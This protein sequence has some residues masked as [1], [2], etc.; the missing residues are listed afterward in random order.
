MPNSNNLQK[1]IFI[2]LIF[3]LSDIFCLAQTTC[4]DPIEIRDNITLCQ[5]ETYQFGSKLVTSP[6]VYIQTFKTLSTNCDSIVTLAAYYL[7]NSN[8]SFTETITTNSSYFFSGKTLTEAG[9]YRDT[10][11]DTNGCDSVLTLTLEVLLEQED[12]TNGIDDDGDGLIDAFDNDCLCL[13]SGVP[14]NLI[15]NGGFEEKV[16]CC[17]AIADPGDLCIDN[18]MN[19]SGESIVYHSPDCWAVLGQDLVIEGIPLESSIMSGRLR[20]NV[21]GNNI[22]GMSLGICLDEPMYAG[23]TYTLTFDIGRSFTSNTSSP[24]PAGINFTVNGITECESLDNYVFDGGFCNKNL[25]FEELIQLNLQELVPKWNHFEFEITPTT[26]IEAIVLAGNC[27]VMVSSFQR[28]HLFYDNFSII[29]KDGL[30]IKNEI[31]LVGSSCQ[32]EPQLSIPNTENLRIDWYKDSVLLPEIVGRPFTITSD[33]TA[34]TNGVYHAKVTFEDGR[35]Q[36]LGPLEI[37]TFNLNLPNDTTLCSEQ[38]LMINMPNPELTYQWQDNST[39]PFYSISEEGLYWVEGTKG[40]CR[41]RD[42][43]LVSYIEEEFLLPSDT[44]LCNATEFLLEVDNASSGQLIWQDGSTDELFLVNQSGTYWLELT[45]N[46][47]QIRD[48]IK[49]IIEP[50]LFELGRDTIICEEETLDLTI[51][52][53]NIFVE[54]QDGSN[55]SN[56][57]V[58]QAG[59]YWATVEKNNCTTR[60]SIS[61]SYEP[62]LETESSFC[63]AYLPN[64]FS[65]N[66]DGVNDDLL[67]LTDCELVYFEMEVYNRWGTRL[68]ATKDKTQSWDGTYKGQLV[69]TGVYLWVTNYQFKDELSPVTEVETVNLLR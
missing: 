34:T 62:C 24:F 57:T 22:S 11:S 67:L 7:N 3:F 56:L 68:F 40:D 53:P 10:L 45:T 29:S 55:S 37:K 2:L 51:T 14:R 26:T 69:E 17:R 66:G 18:W 50:L 27:N 60:D 52:I 31:N 63:Q 44:T 5:G 41:I 4:Q 30:R 23:N 35:C 49:V 19:L 33:I 46:D 20:T 13:I 8:F 28:I 43:I 54:W 39:N 6:G 61:I 12:C 21:L 38:S 1:I 36:L 16:G 15:P 47:C 65:P 48:S 58:S 42:S 59:N 25:P 9:V 32:E 64:S